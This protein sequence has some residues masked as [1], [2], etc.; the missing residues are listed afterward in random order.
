MRISDWS[1]DVCS[2]DLGSPEEYKENLLH[3]KVGEEINQRK[4]L[5]KLVDMQYERNDMNLV[6]GKFRVRGDTIEIHPAYAEMA[7]RVELFGH[8]VERIQQ[9][10]TL[11]G[12]QVAVLADL[13]PYPATPYVP[14]EEPLPT[15]TDAAANEP[16]G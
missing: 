1:S 8:E 3:V 4:V 11:T 6:R 7:V 10:D 12:E 9:V 15:A 14:G 5:R 13:V 16:R 2:S